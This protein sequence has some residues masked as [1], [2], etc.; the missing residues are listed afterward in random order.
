MPLT[1]QP[2]ALK[3]ASPFGMNADVVIHGAER[4][5]QTYKKGALLQD[6]DAGLITETATPCDGSGV[7]H[8]A[9][10]LATADATGTTSHDVLMDY[11]GPYTV[12]EGTLSNATAGTHTLAVGDKFQTY[13]LIKGT[14][15][16]YLDANAVAANGAFILDFKDAVGTVDGRVYFVLTAAA[17]GPVH[18]ASGAL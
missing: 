17:R 10:G 15:N 4:A 8:R 16:W 5:S 1:N 14:Y 13:P 11:I 6:D 18:A 3:L 7:T 9:F 12:L 2:Q